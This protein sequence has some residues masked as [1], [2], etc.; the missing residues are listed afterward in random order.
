MASTGKNNVLKEQSERRRE[1]QGLTNI[2]PQ[3]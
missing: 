3:S 2:R 1:E